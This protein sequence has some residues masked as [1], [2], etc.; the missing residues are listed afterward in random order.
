MLDAGGVDAAILGEGVE[1]VDKKGGCGER[2]QE[3]LRE[4]VSRDRDVLSAQ[5]C[6]LPFA[7]EELSTT[8]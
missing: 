7:R 4:P 8:G 3:G 5:R 1:A 2:E 6:C